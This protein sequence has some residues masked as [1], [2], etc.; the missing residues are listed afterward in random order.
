MTG[1][2]E[3]STTTDGL[4]TAKIPGRCNG[5]RRGSPGLCRRGAGQGTDHVG[6]GYC[7]LHGGSTPSHKVAVAK[8]IARDAVATYG[9]PVD[10]DPH[11]AILQELARTAGAVAYLEEQVRTLKADEVVWGKTEEVDQGAT[12]FPGRNTKHQAAPNIWV[13]LFREERR[14]YLAVIKT[15]HDMGIEDRQIKLAESYGAQL[16][17]VIRLL[18]AGID[19]TPAQMELVPGVLARVIPTITGEVTTIPGEV[20]PDA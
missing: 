5:R 9:L 18:L 16:A 6:I 15:A 12:E 7:A 13:V 14:H 8:S 1:V 20:V 17:V 10:I 2:K 4:A 19:A 11:T 3:S